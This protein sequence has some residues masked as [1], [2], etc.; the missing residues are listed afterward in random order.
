MASLLAFQFAYEDITTSIQS[1]PYLFGSSYST[2]LAIGNFGI[3]NERKKG[4][5]TKRDSNEPGKNLMKVNI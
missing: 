5:A 2:V 4:L 1:D 3:G